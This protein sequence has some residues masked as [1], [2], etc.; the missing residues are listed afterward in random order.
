VL[1]QVLLDPGP[2]A[3][4]QG[5]GGTQQWFKAAAAAAAALDAEEL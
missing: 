5:F 4:T 3:G 1:A 2:G